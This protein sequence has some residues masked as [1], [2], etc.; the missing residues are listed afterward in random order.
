MAAPELLRL[1]RRARLPVRGWLTGPRI[2]LLFAAALLPP[3]VQALSGRGAAL[4]PVLALT[5]AVTFGWEA[6]FAAMRR[7]P[8][9]IAPL[10]PALALALMAPAGAPFWQVGLALSFGVVVGVHLFGGYGWH[11]LNPVIVAMA[12]LLFSFPEAGYGKAPP[13]AWEGVVPGAALLVATGIVSWRIL[14]A[15]GATLAAGL[16]VLPG[17]PV[18][19]F[20]ALSGFAFVLVYLA[21]EPAAAPATDEGRWIYGALVG[22]LVA[23]GL[24]SGTAATEVFVFAVLLGGIFASPI[25]Q[26]VVRLRA[27]RRRR[28]WEG[29]ADG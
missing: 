9:G 21:G 24:V 5:L 28:R 18:G 10:V 16:L 19:I 1:A 2:D 14:L 29:P 25:D 26:A 15:G 17:S 8:M 23:L 12:F 11:F 4:L 6:L 3:L 7:R 22:L 20:V 13:V 27:W